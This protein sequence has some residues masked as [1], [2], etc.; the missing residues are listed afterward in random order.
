MPKIVPLQFFLALGVLFSGCHRVSVETTKP[1]VVV[2]I[3]PQ[4]YF[5]ERIADTLVNI[6]V[7]VPPGSSPETYEPTSS[8]VKTLNNSSIYFSLG[9]LDFERHMLKKI[10]NSTGNTRFVNLS[11]E[12]NLI[13]GHDQGH[14]HHHGHGFDPH[15]WVSPTEVQA[16]V[17]AMNIALSELFPQYDSV[18]S[19]NAK[20]FLTEIDSLH[21]HMLHSFEGT[22]HKKFFIFHPAYSYLA[23]DYDLVQVALEEEGKSPSLKYM[24]A[25]LEEARQLGVKTVFI[26]REFDSNMAK[27]MA[28]DIGGKVVV[29]DPLEYQWLNNMY[30]TVSLLTDALNGN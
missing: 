26:Q 28:Q 11:K 21:M 24:K 7:M 10:E 3:L 19:A 18:F 16:M 30:L 27:T 5:V 17:K 25:I 2:S 8:Q 9:L 23:R 29:I 6:S 15:V 22:V 1:N 13:E 12:F 14:H 20:S 4:K